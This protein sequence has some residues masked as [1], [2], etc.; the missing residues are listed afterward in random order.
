M[1]QKLINSNL[2]FINKKCTIIFLSAI[3]NIHSMFSDRANKRSPLILDHDHLL[4]VI[5]RAAVNL[6]FSFKFNGVRSLLERERREEDANE[7]VS[8]VC[9]RQDS[10]V[11]VAANSQGTIKVL[12]LV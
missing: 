3:Y 1:A 2:M 4:Q 12:E 8:A 6:N 9:W 7:F 5:L 11:V 10:P